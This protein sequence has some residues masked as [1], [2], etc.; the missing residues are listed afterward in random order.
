[1]R[2][3]STENQIALNRRVLIP[4]DFLWIVARNRITNAPETVGFW[5]DINNITTFVIDPDT[6][7]PVTRLYYGAGS[8]I[9]MNDIPSVSVIQVQDISIVMS[10]LD[11]LVEQAVRLYDLKQARIEIHRGLL[12]PESRKLVAPAMIRFVG[13]VNSV[14]INTPSENS[15]GGVVL[16][17]TSHTQELTRSNPSTRAHEDQKFRDSNDDFFIDAAVVPEWELD[18]GEVV[19]TRKMETTKPKGLF[20][21]NNFLGFL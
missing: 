11:E 5:S 2:Q 16:T 20:G 10:Q 12:D 15:D 21:W 7:L 13:F 9:E 6:L 14:T 3:I 18:W 17:C 4:R 19:G 1:M 8:L